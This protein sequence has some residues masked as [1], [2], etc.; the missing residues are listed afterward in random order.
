MGRVCG[1]V[2]SKAMESYIPLLLL[3]LAQTD[4][5]TKKDA[6]TGATEVCLVSERS[7]LMESVSILDSTRCQQYC[8]LTQ[9]CLYW[10]WYKR[11]CDKLPCLD[12]SLTKLNVCYLLTSCRL[13]R[14][15]CD[16]CSSGTK[17]NMK[18]GLSPEK[19]KL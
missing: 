10:T 19:A 9:N 7:L 16:G 8:D 1:P 3:I 12:D 6:R 18:F 11:H 4:C 17:T 2:A 14:Q 15:K 13:S 5:F